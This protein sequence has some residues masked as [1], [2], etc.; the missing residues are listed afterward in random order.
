MKGAGEKTAICLLNEI[1][2]VEEI[3]KHID[4]IASLEFRGAK[5]FA[6]KYIDAIDK[7]HVA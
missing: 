2:G 6:P 7:I 1:G 5:T 4:K 3:L